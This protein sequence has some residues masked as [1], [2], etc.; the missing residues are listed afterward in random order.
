MLGGV[1]E[2]PCRCCGGI[3]YVDDHAS[4]DLVCLDCGVVC[5]ERQ[6][7]VRSEWRTFANETPANDPSRV[8]GPTNHL[9]EDSGLSTV[10]SKGS[11]SSTDAANLS[12]WQNRGSMDGSA[13]NLWSAFREI[14]RM[15]D[16]MRLQR[17]IVEQAQEYYK[18]IEEQKSLRGRG[19]EA[20][21]AASLYIA[22]RK[23]GV[24]RTLK[25]IEALT[26]NANKKEIGRCFKYMLKKLDTSLGTITTKDF[27]VRFT[28]NLKLPNDVCKAATAIA[29][30]AQ[31]DYQ[32]GKC[33][34]SVVAAAIYMAASLSKHKK[35]CKDVSE[36]TG[37]AEVTIRNAY[38]ELWGVRKLLIPADYATPEEIDKLP[39]N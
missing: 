8:G 7:D 3:N 27:M 18:K 24:P 6:I 17:T 5:A 34:T 13:R 38:K 26:T 37:A 11:A 4:G 9:L 35:T 22:C 36:A 2:D 19:M 32:Q 25:E 14:E 1:Q 33:P 10:V 30:K 31:A 29:E 21:I 20:V 23:E 39:N 15:A 12:K 16:K 28:G